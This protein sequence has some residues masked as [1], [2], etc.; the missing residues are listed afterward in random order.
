M[1]KGE[2]MDRDK[3]YKILVATLILTVINLILTII[4]AV[5]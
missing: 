4:K 2:K 3:T 5:L 1:V